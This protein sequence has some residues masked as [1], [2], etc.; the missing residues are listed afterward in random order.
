MLVFDFKTWPDFNIETWKWHD[1]CNAA[2]FRFSAESIYLVLKY[3]IF[4]YTEFVS[5][6][7]SE[8]RTYIFLPLFLLVG[9]NSKPDIIFI[10][11]EIIY[12]FLKTCLF[13]ADVTRPRYAL[14]DA[15]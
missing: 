15:G 13:V 11:A 4:I 3:F 6:H 12:F 9:V 5:W 14:G 1:F 8:V 7:M 10:L 2:I